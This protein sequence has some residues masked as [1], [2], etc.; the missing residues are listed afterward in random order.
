MMVQIDTVESL[1]RDYPFDEIVQAVWKKYEELPVGW[2]KYLGG[3]MARD[4]SF[5]SATVKRKA[6][7]AIAG[8]RAT[9]RVKASTDPAQKVKGVLIPRERKRE[10]E[11]SCGGCGEIDTYMST[12]T[13]AAALQA[14]SVVCRCVWPRPASSY[15]RQ[16]TP[17]SHSSPIVQCFLPTLSLQGG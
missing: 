6:A 14:V 12:D 11:H 7:L 17:S 10:H 3:V 16:I 15:V 9:K 5:A 4:P 2:E 1:V 13:L 8:G